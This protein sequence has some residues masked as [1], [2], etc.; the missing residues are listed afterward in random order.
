MSVTAVEQLLGKVETWEKAFNSDG[1]INE[2]TQV[3]IDEAFTTPDAPAIFQKV[4]SRTLKEAAEPE[5]V[6]SPLF[7]PVRLGKARSFEFQAINALQAAEVG[8][9]M[10]Y[11][12]QALGLAPQREGKVSKKGIKLAFSQEVIDDSM[13]DIV[14]LHVRAAGRA[15]ARLKEQIALR[16]M[17]EASGN[18][19]VF[20]GDD[21]T[22][23]PSGLD[24][25]GAPNGS[26]TWE[27]ILDQAAVLMANDKVPTDFIVHPLAWATFLKTSFLEFN[28]VSSVGQL[29]LGSKEGLYNS[30][31]P[32]GIN[33]IITPFVDFIPGTGGDA[34]KT[35]IFLIDRNDFG[36]HMIRDDLSVDDWND[37]TRDIRSLKMKERYDFVVYGEAENITIAKNIRVA[38][39]WDVQLTKDVGGN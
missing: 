7:T 19:V 27:D 23:A 28:G 18:N 9:T 25:D 16:R 1:F 29:S 36:A 17:K 2:D 11:P 33:T 3:T 31:S 14:G 26:Y 6:I 32:W 34:P 38:K 21:P 15:M 37:L 20:D 24:F 12:E 30:T 10:E 5:Y 35:D 4:V 13:W 39:A 8:E 22:I